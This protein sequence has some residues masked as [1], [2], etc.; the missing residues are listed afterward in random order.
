M[1]GGYF[2]AL[3]EEGSQSDD[4][5]SS[6]RTPPIRASVSS[7]TQVP[8]TTT[9]VHIP[10]YEDLSTSRM[11][12]EL[13]LSTV[14]G[15]DFQ[16]L[17][18]VWGCPRWEVQVRPPDVNRD[19]IGSQLLYV[20]QSDFAL[21]L[22]A[23]I[24]SDVVSVARLSVQLG[25][26]YPY[27][28]PK[29]D[30][31]EIK[32]LSK[33]EHRELLRQLNERSRELAESG[34]VMMV[35]LVQVTEDF[36]VAH[37]T[38][39]NMS[40]WEQMKA[41][42]AAE[43]QKQK[44]VQEELAR[45]MNSD[46][47]KESLPLTPTP[48]ASR[49]SMA[50]P[51]FD[52][53]VAPTELERELVRQRQALEAARVPRLEAIGTR[54]ESSIAPDID[55]DD[56]NEIDFEYD[57]TAALDLGGSSRYLSDFIEL[58][59]LGRG[60]GGEVVKVRNRLDRR[61]YAIKKV[62]LEPERGRFATYGAIQN[63]KLRREVT[64]ISRMT[65][66]NIVRYYQAWVEG[67]GG[68][69]TIQ[70][71]VEIEEESLEGDLQAGD[72]SVEESDDDSSDGWWTQSP[73]GHRMTD[74]MKR[75]LEMPSSDDEDSSNGPELIDAIPNSNRRGDIQANPPLGSTSGSAQS[76]SL[77]SLLEQESGYGLHSP[78]L[79][80]FGFQN[81]TY[82]G[83]FKAGAKSSDRA[84]EV[85][86][87]SW[88]DDD[89][90]VDVDKIRGRA[91]LYI[92]MEFCVRTL[93]KLV[94]D[95]AIAGMEENEVWRMVR[96]TLEALVYIHSRG[97]IH[98]DLKPGNIFLDAE[99]N[100][101]LGDF[102]LATRHRGKTS[103]EDETEMTDSEAAAMYEAIED[104]SRLMGGSSNSY[105]NVSGASST[106]ES[107]TGGVGTT[108]YRAPEQEGSRPTELR[109]K[110]DSSYDSKADIFSFGIILFEI[111]HPPFTTYME[112]A[113]TLT[114]LRGEHHGAKQHVDPKTQGAIL[115]EDDD[116]IRRASERLPRSFMESVPQNAQR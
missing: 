84:S 57:D 6:D 83:L 97:I 42:E 62:I 105:S 13:V 24:Y 66:K 28:V 17:S 75:S 113:E 53:T 33:D 60:G 108:F 99:G 39:P 81:T 37:N 101:R 90:T 102:G 76:E 52:S 61:I 12:E 71:A 31:R 11:D 98:R 9:N 45:L 50:C 8:P 3:Q 95:R 89:S 25:K 116:F 36:L 38:D 107:M 80:G 29:I 19:Q 46:S 93:R 96:Q 14:Y 23:G 103:A 77:V 92:Q 35:E 43:H 54:R 68:T 47:V 88:D 82:Q 20:M 114:I 51:R 86:N 2:S 32:G 94:D 10:A 70:E 63:R 73:K 44:Q 15:D 100:I 109:K 72:K 104:I 67:A 5:S 64:T 87:P 4:G 78:L 79:S 56:E 21:I 69:D 18:G 27:V 110:G 1:S 111:F 85:E 16:S 30:L 59:M 65:H 91:I 40:A 34:S 26:Q 74:D 7:S 55:E 22:V 115:S 48:S 112:R 106:G 58:G 49:P 41:R